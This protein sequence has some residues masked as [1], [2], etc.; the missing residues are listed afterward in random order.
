V[1]AGIEWNNCYVIIRTTFC[2]VAIE[3]E[4]VRYASSSADPAPSSLQR[5]CIAVVNGTV[6]VA[7]K[8]A[9]PDTRSVGY[10][11]RI[12]RTMRVDGRK[13]VGKEYQKTTLC[14]TVVNRY[15]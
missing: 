12:G 10:E 9:G 1:V 14:R 15:M 8:D 6:P 4:I 3:V 7:D 11:Q 13:G 5:Q 2:N